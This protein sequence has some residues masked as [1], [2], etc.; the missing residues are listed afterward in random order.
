V[1]LHARTCWRPVIPIVITRSEKRH[2]PHRAKVEALPVVRHAELAAQRGNGDGPN[3]GLI[4]VSIRD[5]IP[6]LEAV[7]C[8]S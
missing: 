1:P 4:P 6:D 5:L 8:K 3:I 7:V 2:I